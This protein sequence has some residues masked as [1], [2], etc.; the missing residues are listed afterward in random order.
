M[1]AKIL[2]AVFALL[3][4]SQ[5]LG[6]S[7]GS[8]TATATSDVASARLSLLA[9]GFNLTGWMDNGSRRRPDFALLGMLRARGLTHVRL[10]VAAEPLLGAFS[11]RQTVADQLKELDFALQ[12]LLK[13]G[14]AVSL[15]VHP[16]GKFSRLHASDPDEGFRLLQS[17][18]ET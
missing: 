6:A 3:M 17:L 9:R 18:W 8:C 1:R 15:D 4:P 13:I 7:P 10:P 12:T 14:F 16:G 2:I 11:D 5:A